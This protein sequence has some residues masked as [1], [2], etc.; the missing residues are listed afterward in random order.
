MNMRGT[1]R[2]QALYNLARQT[3][4]ERADG[5]GQLHNL[6]PVGFEDPVKAQRKQEEG[7]KVERLVRL[8]V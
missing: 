7:D 2:Q 6:P 3:Q 4:T 5:Q 1:Y 8:F